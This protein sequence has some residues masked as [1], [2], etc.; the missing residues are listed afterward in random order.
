VAYQV[1][2][3]PV[4][5]RDLISI[6]RHIARDNSAA[7]EQII[8]K[9]LKES[10]SLANFPNRGGHYKDR[11]GARFTVVGQYLVVYRVI[12]N[13]KEV[14]ILRYWHSARERLRFDKS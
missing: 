2:I 4:A 6:A 12:E 5:E 8:A 11:P 9:L 7:A 13:T 1:S 3:G 10:R 14:R